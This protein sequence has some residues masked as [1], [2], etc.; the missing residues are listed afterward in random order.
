MESV[1]IPVKPVKHLP[2]VF[3]VDEQSYLFKAA[4]RGAVEQ[5]T[6]LISEEARPK[7]LMS[8]STG[9]DG[10]VSLEIISSFWVVGIWVGKT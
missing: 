7:P 6:S 10:S 4:Q 2:Q 5:S 8:S 3:G 9:R 1:L